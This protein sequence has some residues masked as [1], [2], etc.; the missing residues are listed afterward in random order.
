MAPIPTYMNIRAGP[1]YRWRTPHLFFITSGFALSLCPSKLKITH[2]GTSTYINEGTRTT[3][4]LSLQM[5]VLA[6][7]NAIYKCGENN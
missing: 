5:S 2:A 7:K 4:P 3:P 1:A 6:Q